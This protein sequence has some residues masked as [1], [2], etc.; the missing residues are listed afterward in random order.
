[1]CFM[2]VCILLVVVMIVLLFIWYCVMWVRLGSGGIFWF[3]GYGIWG[4]IGDWFVG[5]EG[6][7]DLECCVVFGCF[8]YFDVFVVVVYDFCYDC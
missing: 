7:V 2:V 1:M 3:G 6:K 5:E 4:W 8:Y